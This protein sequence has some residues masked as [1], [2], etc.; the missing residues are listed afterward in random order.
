L[1]NVVGVLDRD[2]HR[3]FEQRFGVPL[4]PVYGLTEDPMPVLAPPG[5]FPPGWSDKL[6]SSGRPVDPEVHQIRIVDE[7]GRDLPP[8]RTG[9]IVKRSPA[10]MVG[11]FKDPAATAAVLR[12]G[13]LA[14]GDLG[15]LD[16]DGFLYF[17][18]RKKDVIRR[19]GEMIAAAEVEVTISSHPGI[20]EV[21][22][23]G[24]PDP[25]RSE[26]VKAFVVLVAGRSPEDV[27]PV[28]I[29]EHCARRLAPFKV[30]RYIEYREELPRTATLKLRKEGLRAAEGSHQGEHVFDRQ[31]A[32]RVTVPRSE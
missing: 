22:V 20:A 26:E 6:E 32:A 4:V 29:L 5:G 2:S 25:I 28:E 8:R 17:V 30:P 1:R 21:A 23:I 14:T 9:E 11:Y 19:S 7:E 10:T 24:V 3:A 16:E 27:P 15:Y 18:S 13:W 31:R 12:D